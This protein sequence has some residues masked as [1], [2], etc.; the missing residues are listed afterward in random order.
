MGWCKW[1]KKK[2]D[3]RQSIYCPKHTTDKQCYTCDWYSKK[4]VKR[5]GII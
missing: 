1:Y 2:V 4:E 5:A 3:G